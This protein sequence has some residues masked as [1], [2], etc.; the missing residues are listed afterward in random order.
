MNV[1]L[2]LRQ[3]HNCTRKSEMHHPQ[4]RSLFYVCFC[5]VGLRTVQGFVLLSQQNTSEDDKGKGQE[6]WQQLVD[7]R[8]TADVIT[9]QQSVGEG[10]TSKEVSLHRTWHHLPAWR[11]LPPHSVPAAASRCDDLHLPS[12]MSP[13]KPQS[14]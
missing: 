5:C 10:L 7:N 6:S 2:D 12:A 8:T 11:Q 3:Q 14:R 13:Y 4:L 1:D 9:G